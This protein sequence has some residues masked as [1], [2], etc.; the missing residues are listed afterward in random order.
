MKRIKISSDDPRCKVVKML[1]FQESIQLDVLQL[2]IANELGYGVDPDQSKFYWELRLGGYLIEFTDEIYAG[3]YILLTRK[4]TVQR[5]RLPYDM[6]V[7]A[8]DDDSFEGNDNKEGAGF[9]L[10]GGVSAD[11]QEPRRGGSAYDP[12]W[13]QDYILSMQTQNSLVRR[14]QL[15]YDMGIVEADDDSYDG[16]DNKEG[17]GFSLA[18]GVSAEDNKKPAAKG[19]TV[20]EEDNE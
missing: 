18:G 9:S 11:V 3:D 20:A 6:G 17:A 2:K 10:A 12:E 16:N 1:C 7:V 19:S 5:S 14:S 8:G 13:R 4:E 15:S